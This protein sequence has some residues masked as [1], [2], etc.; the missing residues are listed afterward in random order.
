MMR[1]T[2]KILSIPPYVSTTWKNILSLHIEVRSSVPILVLSLAAG[3]RI[4]IPGMDTAAIRAIFLAHAQY[5]DAET[6]QEQPLKMLVKTEDEGFLQH[7]ASQANDNDLP[8]ELL[9]KISSLSEALGIRDSALI[10]QAETNC[11]CPHCQIANA[12]RK[13]LIKEEVAEEEIV[14]DDDLKFRTWDIAKTADNLYTVSNPLDSAET[15]SVY[16]G[17]PVGCTCGNP[18]CEHIRAVLKS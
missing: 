8:V 3:I 12:L 2:P 18:H 7:D 16:L 5:A 11:N 9:Q 1:I 13:G 4:E 10:P 15:Y 17:Q 6:L 14:T